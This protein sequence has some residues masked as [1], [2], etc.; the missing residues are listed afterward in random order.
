MVEL[1]IV[2]Q[3]M[4]AV[5]RQFWA[6]F[7]AAEFESVLPL[8]HPNFK[9]LMPNTQEQYPDAQSFIAF[10]R[11]YPGRWRIHVAELRT[12]AHEVISVVRVFDPEGTASFHAISFFGFQ[13][14][15]IVSLKEYW[16]EDL[17]VPEWRKNMG[18]SF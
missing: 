12:V 3:V 11:A 9:A 4:E 7:D 5:I 17:E 10:N 14:G 2:D 16:S 8:M 6:H 13:D 1:E 18:I 15:L